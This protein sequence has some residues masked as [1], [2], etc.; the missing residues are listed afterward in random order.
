MQGNG[1]NIYILRNATVPALLV[2]CGYMDNPSDLKYLQDEKNQ[3]KIARDILEGI[4]KYSMETTRYAPPVVI[5]ED[6][7]PTSDTLSQEGLKKIDVSKIES[8]NVDRDAKLITVT[9]KDGRKYYEII[10]PEM[11]HSWDSLRIA[12]DN[13]S[14]IVNANQAVFT[15]VEVEAEYPGGYRPGKIIY[16]RI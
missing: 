10:T 15:K 1:T 3:E 2:E 9:L 5:S 8:M 7:I 4:R 11:L 12:R 14:D 13:A 16:R 6:S